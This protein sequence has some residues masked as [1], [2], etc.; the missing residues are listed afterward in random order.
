MHPMC[1]GMIVYNFLKKKSNSTSS[2]CFFRCISHYKPKINLVKQE[3]L[4]KLLNDFA[5]DEISETDY[6]LLAEYIQQAKND[7]ALLYAM[8]TIWL[9][10]P[11]DKIFTE[12]QSDVLY[13]KIT[14]SA[15]FK[16]AGNNGN[17]Q[18]I[19]KK[20]LGVAAAV[21]LSLSVAL[22]LMQR[23]ANQQ[24]NSYANKTKKHDIVPG[25]N[26]AYLT[27]AN[28]LKIILNDAKNGQLATAPGIKVSKTKDGMLV[29]HY[30]GANNTDV[31]QNTIE[32]NTITTPR[33]G[34]YQIVFVDGTKVWLNA[35]S[36]LK[37][38]TTFTGN[39]RRVELTGEAYF[40]V[41]KNKQMPFDVTAKGINVEVLGT[42][43]NVSAYDDDDDIQ[44]TLLEGSVKVHSHDKQ[45]L[46][47]PGQQASYGNNTDN[48]NIKEVNVEDA[49][50]WKNGYFVFKNDNIYTIMKKVSRW[51]D[52]DIEYQG[53][54]AK[55]SFGGTMSRFENV[56][57]LLKTLEMTGTT[58]FK[59]QER[60][61]TVMP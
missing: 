59:I 7:E 22:L 34:Q 58:H 4:Y 32:Y 2:F 53:L 42:H 38:P 17:R 11:S 26:K 61:I 5:N 25:G 46:L 54:P 52:V 56:S 41:A 51:Y 30:T 23:P 40:E 48:L 1:F 6:D 14:G 18:L 12:L 45:A 36:S 49:I 15:R 35:Q 55:T 43:F 50:A 16:A 37:F 57:E 39:R 33:G 9:T 24:L 8:E 44:T 10:I 21:I 47:I 28:G 20:W 31:P 60:R 29:Y 13:K 3:Q 27:L 19:S